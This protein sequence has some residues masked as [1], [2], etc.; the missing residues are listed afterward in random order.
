MPASSR[1]R[2]R[3]AAARGRAPVLSR[4]PASTW[5]LGISVG[6]YMVGAGVIGVAMGLA[7]LLS[8]CWGRNAF[9]DFVGDEWVPQLARIGV[10]CSLM[11]MLLMAV[12]VLDVLAQQSI[13]RASV[14]GPPHGG[15][16]A[17]CRVPQLSVDA[18]VVS[19][20]GGQYVL[21]G[22]G[23]LLNVANGGCHHVHSQRAERAAA[24]GELRPLRCVEI[25]RDAVKAVLR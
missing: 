15:G 23:E 2:R 8:Y 13:D 12:P 19:R 16:P 1:L 10:F 25:P 14:P 4:T 6:K 20:V 22:P 3:D 17:V 24:V 7:V 11:V 5:D 18:D 21:T 9:P